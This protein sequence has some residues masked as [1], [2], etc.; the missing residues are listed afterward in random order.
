MSYK[1][2]TPGKEDSISVSTTVGES[3]KQAFFLECETRGDMPSVILRKCIYQYLK[4]NN[5]N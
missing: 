1:R 4:N 5:D 2:K 3:I